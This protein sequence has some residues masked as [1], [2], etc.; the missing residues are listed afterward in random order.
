M[1]S[2]LLAIT[3]SLSISLVRGLLE[4]ERQCP[5]FNTLDLGRKHVFASST[6]GDNDSSSQYCYGSPTIQCNTC[7]D[8]DEVNVRNV[9]D[10]NLT[11]HWI[12]RPGVTTANLT[13]DLLGVCVYMTK[14]SRCVYDQG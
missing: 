4:S 3:I 6:C 12:S 8:E 13:V 9:I 5:T 11:S 2:F 7:D 1:K 14:G 10:G